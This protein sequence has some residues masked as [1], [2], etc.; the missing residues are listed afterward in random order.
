[1]TKQIVT[2][3][4]YPDGDYGIKVS[5][6]V[7]DRTIRFQLNREFWD[8]APGGIKLRSV[9]S[10]NGDSLVQVMYSEKTAKITRRVSGDKMVAESRIG[11]VIC[12][13]IYKRIN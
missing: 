11:D 1:M 8:E 10:M 2:Y 9:F 12:N 13:R 6:R 5:S 7:Y 3:F 4:Q